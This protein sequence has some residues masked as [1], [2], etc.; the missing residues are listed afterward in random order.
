MLSAISCSELS[1]LVRL[2][3]KGAQEAVSGT[4]G[5]EGGGDIRLQ[6]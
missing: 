6:P 2:P 1:V 5:G 3:V 4:T